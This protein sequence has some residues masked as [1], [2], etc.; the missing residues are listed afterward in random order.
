MQSATK[1]KQAIA[2]LFEAPIKLGQNV[3]NKLE[4]SMSSRNR[5][6]KVHCPFSHISN[7]AKPNPSR[8]ESGNASEIV[9]SWELK[10]ECIQI[11]WCEQHAF[12]AMKPGVSCLFPLL[13]HLHAHFTKTHVHLHA[14]RPEL[15]QRISGRK[16]IAEDLSLH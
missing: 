12:A 4:Q 7:A 1:P 5:Q 8:L 13:D 10:K 14:S 11:L 16:W 15:R 2:M 9:F 3:S 6:G